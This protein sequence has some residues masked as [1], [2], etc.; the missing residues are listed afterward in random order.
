VCDADACPGASTGPSY[1]N[2]CDNLVTD[3]SC[4][5]TCT[6]GYIGDGNGIHT[7]PAGNFTGTVLTCTPEPSVTTTVE[8]EFILQLTLTFPSLDV[9]SASQS[10]L[11]AEVQAI[12][13]PAYVLLTEFYDGSLIAA[14]RIFFTSQSAA[15]EF[16][17][18][19]DFVFQGETPTVEI[20]D[21]STNTNA[22][23]SASTL[24]ISISFAL[25]AATGLLFF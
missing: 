19:N 15:D 12:V 23:S 22:L 10:D 11:T 2:E 9:V 25:A 16:D 13:A 3:G 8:A 7:C 20:S 1:G 18:P 24:S 17:F 21:V 6:A 14:F 5:Q 4:T